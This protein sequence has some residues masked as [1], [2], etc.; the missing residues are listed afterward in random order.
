MSKKKE[1]LKV[2][3]FMQFR[4]RQSNELCEEYA[5]TLDPRQRILY[6]EDEH[7]TQSKA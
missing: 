6:N 4:L 2:D 7:G 5:E 1:E 3:K